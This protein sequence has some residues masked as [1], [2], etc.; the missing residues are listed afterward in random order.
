MV[1]TLGSVSAI[2]GDPARAANVTRSSLSFAVIVE[3]DRL[4]PPQRPE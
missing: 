1:R 2:A 4:I 3:T